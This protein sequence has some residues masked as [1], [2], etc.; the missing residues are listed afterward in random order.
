MGRS[1]GGFGTKIHIVCDSKGLPI[2]VQLTPGQ[3]H[4]S[5]YCIGLIDSFEIK[6]PI[7]RPGKRPDKLAG[8]KG[9]TSKVIEKK[10]VSRKIIPIIPTRSNQPKIQKFDKK[11]YRKRNIIERCIGWIKENRRIATRYEKLSINYLA[12]LKLGMIMR[13]LP[14]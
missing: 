14:T 5:C 2:N 1:R 8:D 3:C 4:E 12:M 11:S 9:Y 6:G 10:L 13:Y 7:G